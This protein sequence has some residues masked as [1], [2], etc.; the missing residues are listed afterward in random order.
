MLLKQDVCRAGYYADGTI[1][2]SVTMA[3]PVELERERD[4]TSTSTSKRR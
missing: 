1:A 2:N 4:A 3:L